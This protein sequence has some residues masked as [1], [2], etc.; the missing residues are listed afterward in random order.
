MK[1]I[2]IELTDRELVIGTQDIQPLT[3][4]QVLKMFYLLMEVEGFRFGILETTL[5]ITLDGDNFTIE[6]GVYDEW[7]E[8]EDEDGGWG[9]GVK[10]EGTMTDLNKLNRYINRND[11]GEN[12]LSVSFDYVIHDGNICPCDEDTHYGR[13][14]LSDDETDKIVQKLFEDGHISDNSNGFITVY[15][16]VIVIEIDGEDEE[17]HV[18]K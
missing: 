3:E 1:T 15:D 5:Y 9:V 4:L 13:R 10:Y 6:S 7:V 8:D 11:D 18:Y 14:I 2:E 16:D 12:P 17:V